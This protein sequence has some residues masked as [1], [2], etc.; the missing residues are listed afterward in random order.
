MPRPETMHSSD[1][2]DS[3][4]ERGHTLPLSLAIISSM[5][6]FRENWHETHILILWGGLFFCPLILSRHSLCYKQS[7]NPTHCLS[8]CVL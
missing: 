4:Y 8:N 5:T 7:E 3:D 1:T 6:L 2:M